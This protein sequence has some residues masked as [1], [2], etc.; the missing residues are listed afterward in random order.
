MKHLN[1]IERRI[2]I[3]K[4]ERYLH[5]KRR[6]VLSQWLS[7]VHPMTD[8]IA[9]QEERNS[10]NNKIALLTA[11]INELQSKNNDNTRHN[12]LVA[13]KHYIEVE[14]GERDILEYSD[15]LILKN[16]AKVKRPKFNRLYNL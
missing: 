6:L 8:K 10:L 4:E 5:E 2:D 11:Q 9:W 15:H 1:E 14:L 12:Y 7:E 16:T 3:L 13:L